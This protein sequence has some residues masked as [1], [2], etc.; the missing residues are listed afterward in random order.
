MPAFAAEFRPGGRPNCSSATQSQY[1]YGWAADVFDPL[2]A[3][4][5]RSEV[6]RDGNQCANLI[7]GKLCSNA[8]MIELLPAEQCARGGIFGPSRVRYPSIGSRRFGSRA[9]VAS[10]RPQGSASSEGCAAG[11]DFRNRPL[12]GT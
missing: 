8:L 1:Q 2:G 3:V 7:G 10:K 11:R 9:Y 12:V 4:P 6:W 5:A